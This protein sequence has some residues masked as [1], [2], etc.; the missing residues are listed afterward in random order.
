MLG[1][2][3]LCS[4]RKRGRL[5]CCCLLQAEFLIWPQLKGSRR[6][7]L[8]EASSF[9]QGSLSVGLSSSKRSLQVPL[10][11]QHQSAWVLARLPLP[12]AFP[13][14]IWK[15]WSCSWFAPP[16]ASHQ[17]VCLSHESAKT[18]FWRRLVLLCPAAAPRAE[19]LP[20]KGS[21]VGPSY[22]L[23]AV[24]KFARFL[25]YKFQ[26]FSLHYKSSFVVILSNLHFCYFKET[27]GNSMLYNIPALFPL[28]ISLT[29]WPGKQ[30]NVVQKEFE[31][32]YEIVGVKFHYTAKIC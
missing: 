5:I 13:L 12:S 9:F 26:A 29:A 22:S 21:A 32:K 11:T 17:R 4:S 10:E 31:G 28:A 24:T 25:S 2:H 1:G 19:E 30:S 18:S 15:G 23:A 6:I 14:R 16:V 20:A 7:F 3:G 27:L 8:Q